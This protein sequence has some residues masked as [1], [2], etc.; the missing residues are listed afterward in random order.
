MFV[1]SVHELFKVRVTVGSSVISGTEKPKSIS[2]CR[3]LRLNRDE[4]SGAPPTL[5]VKL[6]K[7][8]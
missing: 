7:A 5:L 6:N 3:V 2:V 8:S 1:K 4:G